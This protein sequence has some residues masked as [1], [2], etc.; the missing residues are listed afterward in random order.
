MSQT[1]TLQHELDNLLASLQQARGGH[2]LG[3]LA[4]LVYC[5]VRYWARHAGETD[6]ANHSTTIFTEQPHESR[7]A[8]LGQVDSLIQELELVRAKLLG[9]TLSDSSPQDKHCAA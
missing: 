8:F 2:D 1:N 6:I 5:E 9:P 3:K 7:N 4:L